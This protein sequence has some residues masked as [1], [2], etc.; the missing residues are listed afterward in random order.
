MDKPKMSEA[1]GIS[2]WK[3]QET[4]RISEAAAD[5]VTVNLNSLRGPALCW[6]VA[7]I[8]GLALGF[9]EPHYGVGWRIFLPKCGNAYRPDVNWLQGGPLLDKYA[10]LFGMLQ[11][12]RQPPECRAFAVKPGPEGFRRIAKGETILIA[13]CRALVRLHLGDEVS[14]PRVLVNAA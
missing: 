5:L 11:D 4:Q 8:E 7:Q 10:G 3:Q 9:A 14:V 6:A 1:P 13:L 12:K 2:Q